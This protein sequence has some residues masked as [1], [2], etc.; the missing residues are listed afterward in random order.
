MTEIAPIYWRGEL[1]GHMSNILVDMF[2]WDGDWQPDENHDLAD[3]LAELSKLKPLSRENWAYN[4]ELLIWIG[5]FHNEP[6]HI[7]IGFEDGKLVT[8]MIIKA[9]KDWKDV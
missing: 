2:Y 1:V 7:A 3:F 5:I 6:T 8:R 4:Q 9:P